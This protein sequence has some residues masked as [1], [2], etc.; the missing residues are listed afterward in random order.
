VSDFYTVTI[1]RLQL[2][3]KFDEHG[4][5]VGETIT[6]IPVTHCDLPYSTALMY[7]QKAADPSEVTIIR[8]I[9]EFTPG[10]QARRAEDYLEGAARFGRRAETKGIKNIGS[11]DIAGDDTAIEREISEAAKRG[12]FAAAISAELEAS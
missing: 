2:V 6:K 10:R 1:N 12:D 3:S 5:K 7:Q 8:Q 9:R 11:E 4:K